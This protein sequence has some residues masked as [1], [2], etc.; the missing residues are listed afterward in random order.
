MA[1]K[2]ELLEAKKQAETVLYLID[3]AFDK[4]K[5]AR[6]W[7]IY[8]ILSGGFLSSMVKRNRMKEVNDLL[9]DIEVGLNLLSEELEDV[10][11]QFSSA[12]NVDATSEFFDMWF[13]N[14]FTDLAVQNNIKEMS[15][16]LD[17]LRHHI[18][19]IDDYLN[20]E[21]YGV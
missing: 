20:R 5:S 1:E 3:L 11:V 19:N 17:E 2:L 13:D 10:Q 8:D 18:L 4:L 6:S 14:I 16:Q 21:I 12:F 9:D 15:D 7:G